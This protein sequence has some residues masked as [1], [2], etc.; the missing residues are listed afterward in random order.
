M[1]P[2]Y[3]WLDR[4]GAIQLPHFTLVLSQEELESALKHCK[5]LPG[6]A[7]PFCPKAG[8]TWMLNVDGKRIAIVGVRDH[9]EDGTEWHPCTVAAL[10][11]HE[12]VHIF[13]WW[14][15]GVGETNP[16]DEFEAYCIQWI[17]QQLFYE[18]DR[19]RSQQ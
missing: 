2:P 14:C 8:H 10:L 13:Q 1:K 12:A 18:Y 16:S 4:M 11:V 9:D 5:M 19:R 6:E 17:S 3:E 15:D 7:G